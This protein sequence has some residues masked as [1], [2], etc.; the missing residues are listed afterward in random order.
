V[1]DT[2]AR[3]ATQRLQEPLLVRRDYGPTRAVLGD[4]VQLCQVF[5]NLL[6]N[7]QHALVGQPSAGRPDAL[8]MT[9][10]MQSASWVRVSVQD[11]GCGM[12]EELVERVFQPFFTTKPPTEGSGLGLWLCRDILARFG[13]SISVKSRVG[14]GTLFEVL[15]PAHAAR[16]A[17]VG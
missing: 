13:G 15:L 2:A 8:V 12:S 9:T 10:Q 4:E 3:L 5:V 1:L 17:S 11:R 16:D 6:L 14:E 7:A